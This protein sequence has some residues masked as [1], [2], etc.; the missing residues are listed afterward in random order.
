MLLSKL[1][2]YADRP[3]APGM[4]QLYAE[5]PLRYIIEID[6]D[7][8]C[9]AGE[10]I[11]LSDPSSDRSRR[12]QRRPLPQVQR[13]SGIKPLLLASPADYTLGL[14]K[15][16]KQEERARKCHEAYMELLE[17]CVAE[18]EEPSVISVLKFLRNNPLDH[19]KLD[20]EFDK[21]GIIT[22]RI[23]GE[24]RPVIDLPEV[25]RFWAKHN[26]PEGQ[27]M[28]CLVCGAKRTVLLRLQSKIKG[29]PGGQTSGTSIISANSDA[30]ESYGL[31]ESTIA[32]VC[33]ECAEKFTKGCNALLASETN[34]LRANNGIYIFWTKGNEEY[35]FNQDIS[36]PDPVQVQALLES[37]KTGKPT[38]ADE[39]AFY[40]AYLS[41][42]GGRA[43]VK[44]WIDTTVGKAKENLAKWFQRQTIAPGSDGENRYY[45]LM[46]LAY[47]TV[48]ERKDLHSSTVRTLFNTAIQGKPL[49]RYILRQAVNRCRVERE[50]KRPRAALIKLALL[51]QEPHLEESYMAEKDQDNANP[52]YLCGRLFAVLERA[53]TAAIPK[54]NATIVERQY[55]TASTAPQRVFPALMKGAQAHLSKLRRDKP[56]A[57]HGI[58]SEIGEIT[59]KLEEFPKTLKLEEQGMF[60][61]GYYH[62]RAEDMKQA[63]E[64]KSR[65]ETD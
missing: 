64:A 56:G 52:G 53:Q 12:G 33:A 50:I 47:S 49:P 32:P 48:R 4:P 51:S 41:G 40:A 3:D 45:G 23:S 16:P 55:G 21:G 42:S 58:Q 6:Y 11:D 1:A 22:F 5:G 26:Q 62:Q 13:T 65:S 29:I 43:V 14:P 35:D 39:T 59:G 46:P 10:L 28:Q 18:T 27:T 44:D 36:M 61:L 8:V 25:Q 20:E 37:A 63:R 57:Y 38:D 24:Q 60:A 7:G 17:K 30:Y 15:N 19:L 9:R 2:E 31:K 34:R 54:I